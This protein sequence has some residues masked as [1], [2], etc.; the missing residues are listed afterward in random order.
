MPR[1]CVSLLRVERQRGRGGVDDTLDFFVF[2]LICRGSA[3][4]L[5]LRLQAARWGRELQI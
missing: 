4:T 2:E 1:R 3:A 5:G